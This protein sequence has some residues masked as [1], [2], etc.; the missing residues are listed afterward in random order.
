MEELKSVLVCLLSIFNVWLSAFVTMW[1]WN[2]L[3]A[4]TFAVTVLSFWQAFGVDLFVS[5]LRSNYRKKDEIDPLERMVGNTL[6][7]LVFWGLGGFVS[8]FI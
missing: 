8:L 6:L 1:L 2:N 4:V 3:I 7:A 5:Y